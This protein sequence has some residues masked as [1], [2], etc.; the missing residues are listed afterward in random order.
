MSSGFVILM[1]HPRLYW[2]AAGN[3]LMPALLELPISPDYARVGWADTTPIM[4]ATPGAVSASRTYDAFNQNGWGRS[5]H[6]LVAWSLVI[7][8]AVYL[9]TGALSGHLRSQLWPGSGGYRPLQKAAYLAVIVVLAPL[10]VLTGMTMSPRIGATFPFLLQ[11]FGGFQ[12]A[13]TLH[14]AGF[15]LLL[16]FVIGHIVMVIKTG[17]RRQLRGM[18]LG[19]G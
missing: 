19:K 8:G 11:L 17:F 10:Q 13:R 16:L 18:I 9:L 2:G 5:L 1:A 14:F 4:D 6:F 3:D 15:V 7:V 12:S